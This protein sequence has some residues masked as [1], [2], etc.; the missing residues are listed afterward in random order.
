VWTVEPRR[1]AGVGSQQWRD[2]PGGRVELPSG[3]SASFLARDARSPR[4]WLVE[5]AGAGDVLGYLR[6]HGQPIR[7]AHERRARS[8]SAYQTVYAN[9]PGSAEMP[10]AG[11]P[12]TTKLV[13]RLASAGVV[14]APVVLHCGVASFEA[15]ELPDS[16]RY[17]VG[18]TT[19]RLVNQA[20]EAGRRVVAIGTTSARAIETV[21]DS[22]GE[23]HPGQGTTDLLITPARGVRAIDGIVTGW[24]EAG[25]SHL[26][27]VEAVAGPGLVARCYAEAVERGYLWHEFGDSLLVM[28]KRRV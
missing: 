1:P 25:A 12:F 17:R 19:A 13:T 26:Q 15:G 10:S 18:E 3:A 22:A 14:F 27:L 5:L 16:E 7:Y 28:T 24:H 11:R 9:E 21:T 20:H 8:L 2:F 6:R 4:L 23:V